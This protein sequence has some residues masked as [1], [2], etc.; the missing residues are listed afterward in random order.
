MAGTEARLP[1]SIRLVG[2]PV[3]GGHCKVTYPC[4]VLEYLYRE[5]KYSS[6]VVELILINKHKLYQLQKNSVYLPRVSR[7][8]DIFPSSPIYMSLPIKIILIQLFPSA[9]SRV[10]FYTDLYQ[11]SSHFRIISGYRSR[12]S[13]P[14]LF[15]PVI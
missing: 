7:N 15:A 5:T 9:N 8:M 10:Y 2:L 13:S 14:K 1:P 11:L 6:P 12:A 3:G 4:P